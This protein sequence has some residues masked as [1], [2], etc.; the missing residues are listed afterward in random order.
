V[1][2]AQAAAGRVTLQ[3]YGRRA[4]PE[5]A[6]QAL[7]EALRT[8]DSAGPDVILAADVGPDGLG[9]AIRDRLARAA[10]GRVIKLGA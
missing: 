2:A 5:D 7:F 4:A 10:E 8:L 3:A 1:L 6:A 9:A